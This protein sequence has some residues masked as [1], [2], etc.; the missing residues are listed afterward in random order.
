LPQD[1]ALRRLV[2][3]YASAQRP[4]HQP[5]P[6]RE[7]GLIPVDA[8]NRMLPPVSAQEMN[9][10]SRPPRP[11]PAHGWAGVLCP[12]CFRLREEAQMLYG[13]GALPYAREVFC[14]RCLWRDWKRE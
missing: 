1:E 8:Y 12:R 14:P 10:P 4:P 11:G 7:S 3:E 9:G 5:P 6:P 13:A 2:P